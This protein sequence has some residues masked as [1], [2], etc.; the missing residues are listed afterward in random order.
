[1]PIDPATGMP[2]DPAMGGEMQVPTGP[3]PQYTP[4]T[5]FRVMMLHDT[6]ATF[7]TVPVDLNTI[8][9]DEDGWRMLYA[10]LSQMRSTPDVSGPVRRVV[11]TGDKQDTFALA[12]MA[13]V[14]ETGKMSASIRQPR[15]EFNAQIAEVT[16]KPGPVTLVADVEA[17]TADPIIEWN[18]DADNV[19]NIPVAGAA[20]LAMDPAM[21]GVDPA[22]AG[23][24]PGMGAPV[25]AGPRIDA[26]GITARFTYPDE[27]QNYRVEITVRDRRGVK[28]PAKASIIVKVRA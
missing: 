6:G 24:D 18:F 22:M 3:P 8:Q 28:A 19:G 20:P 11:L 14:V 21:M 26:K 2:F 23:M 25:P 13:L 7:G 4:I 15:D 1:M 27:E 12:Q 16:V 9:P 5:R 10:P 17:G